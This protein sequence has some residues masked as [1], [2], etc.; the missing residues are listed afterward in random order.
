MEQRLTL[1]LPYYNEAGF[2]G[3]TLASLAAQTCR[4]FAL[5]LVDNNSADGGAAKARAACAA[6]SDIPV[7]FL[8]EAEPGKLH[9]LRTGLAKAETALVG[10]IDADTHFPPEYVARILYLF[11]RQPGT[12][13]AIA[14]NVGE[15]RSRRRCRKLQH[16]Q[17][18]L[19]P[20]KAHGGGT[21][22]AF[23]R[24]MFDAA[25][26]FDPARWPFVLEDHE[27]VHAVGKLGTIAWSPDHV[28]HASERRSD[29]SDCS[30][31]V[32]ERVLYKLLPDR[33]MDWFFYRFLARR[34]ERR[35]LVN[36]RL[37][38]QQ[39]WQVETA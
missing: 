28:C 37:R 13:M 38:E 4:D 24:R 7:R 11:D 18:R 34:F 5:V 26:G 14:F 36:M 31:T 30:W 33:A 23:D 2:I 8:H 6:M 3:D 12:A 10:T 29:R 21:C 39:Q 20:R 25:G 16:V 27:I 15:D 32:F 17:A 35:G 9:A 22:Q 1:V 19:F